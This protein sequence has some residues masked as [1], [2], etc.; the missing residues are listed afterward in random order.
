MNKAPAKP[1]TPKQKAEIDKSV[2]LTVQKYRKT[3]LRL[4]NT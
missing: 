3:L 1:L 2:K 4:A